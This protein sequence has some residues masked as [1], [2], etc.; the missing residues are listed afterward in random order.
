M[1]GLCDLS[2]RIRKGDTDMS[3]LYYKAVN[4]NEIHDTLDQYTWDKL[5]NN[6]WLDTRIPVKE[7][8]IVW[9]A[10]DGNQQLIIGNS[11]ACMS[12]NAVLQSELGA[13]SLRRGIQTQQEEA[14]LNIT[15]FMESVH[16]KSITTIFRALTNKEQA[17]GYYRF[18]D[19]RQDLQQQLDKLI[20]VFRNDNHLQKTVAFILLETALSFGKYT[21]VLMNQELKQTNQMVANMIR[22]GSIYSTYLGYK[23]QLAFQKLSDDDRKEIINW[24]EV[25]IAEMVES[26][27]RFLVDT[28]GQVEVGENLLLLGANYTLMVLGFEKKYTVTLPSQIESIMNTLLT[29]TDDLKQ[30]ATKVYASQIEEMDSEDYTF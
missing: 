3:F 15:T 11:L 9:K 5:T 21:P 7:D 25:F 30:Q 2:S 14:V 16:T 27:K 29:T 22:G 13:A 26:E 10:L 23:F 8:E 17:E 19:A 28:L 4:W 12:L 1:S 6:F 18:A 24:I 20:E